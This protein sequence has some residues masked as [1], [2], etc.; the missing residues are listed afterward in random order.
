[1]ARKFH[2]IARMLCL[3][4]TTLNTWRIVA[5][6][7]RGHNLTELCKITNCKSY[8]KLSLTI[9]KLLFSGVISKHV[10]VPIESIGQIVSIA[11]LEKHQKANKL[12]LKRLP[13]LISHYYAFT[14]SATEIYYVLADC[15]QIEEILDSSACRL[16]ICERVRST[17]VPL[18]FP[19]R[20]EMRLSLLRDLIKAGGRALDSVDVDLLLDIFRLFNP[21]I[22]PINRNKNLISLLEQRLG[23]KGVRYHYYKHVRNYTISHYTIKNGGDFIL[24]LT[25]TPTFRELEDLLNALIKSQLISGVWQV[26]CLTVE[27]VTA[28]V[29]SWGQL[30]KLVDPEYAHEYIKNAHY[31]VYPVIGVSYGAPRSTPGD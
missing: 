19:D 26:F 31:T 22:E 23:V 29:H 1:M 12:C 14:G 20:V 18:E 16:E 10:V 13:S 25:Y 7:N 5:L 21:P 28:L 9:N 30:D 11:I 4:D 3:I 2:I 27:P 15:P 8:S 17:L 24:L 6:L